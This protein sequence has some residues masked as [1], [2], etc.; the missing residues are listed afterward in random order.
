MKTKLAENYSP[1]YFLSSLGNGGLSI[2]FF[3]YLLFMTPHEKMPIPTFQTLLNFS[4]SASIFENVLLIIVLALILFFSLM[5]IKLLIWNI[6]EY[7]LFKTTSIYEN[8]KSSNAEVQLMAL[9]LTFGMSIN[10]VFILGALFIP[11][12]WSVKEYLFPFAILGFGVVGYFSVKIFLDYSVRVLTVG[13]FNIEKNNNLSQMLGVFA[14]SMIAVG[15]SASSAMSHNTT[16]SAIAM[17]FAILFLSITLIFSI[18]K[19]TTGFMSMLEHKMD[20]ESSVSLW[21]VIPITTLIGITIYRLMMAS[22]YNFHSPVDDMNIVVLF[23]VIASIQILFGLLGYAVMKKIGYFK[24]FLHG[25]E[26]SPASYAL[27]CPGVAGVVMG[28]FFLNRAIL[29]IGLV[30]KFSVTY[31][32]LLLPIILLQIKTIQTLFK[33]NKKLIN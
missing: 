24:D 17:F 12:L 30:D 14:F 28:F 7:K 27:V 4:N 3:M 8:L 2:T 9:P 16:T 21:I 31:F 19:I 1:L 6:K 32:I 20:K 22:K 13:K 11:G 25:N 23:S 29:E 18:I 15:F 10:V 5:H 26:K 33:L